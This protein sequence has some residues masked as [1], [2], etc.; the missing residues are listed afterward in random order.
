MQ[1][2]FIDNHFDQDLNFIATEEDPVTKKVPIVICK[3]IGVFSISPYIMHHVC[4]YFFNLLC[5]WLIQT[6]TRL[7]LN[8]KP[9]DIGSIIFGSAGDDPKMLSNFKDLLDKIFALDP[10]KRITVSQ[11]LAHPFITGK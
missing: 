7:V 11:A 5:N 4:V 3:N 10:D 9:K 6:I 2:A 1:G 8:I